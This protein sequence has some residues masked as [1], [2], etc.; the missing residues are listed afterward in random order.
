[1]VFDG[2]FDVL[3]SFKIFSRKYHFVL[4]EYNLVGGIC[5]IFEILDSSKIFGR[6]CHFVLGE[7]NLVGGLWRNF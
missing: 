4:G 6:N 5:G 1:M 2:I 7:Y 3:N